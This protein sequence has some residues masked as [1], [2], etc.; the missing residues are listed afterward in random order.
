MRSLKSKI[1][2]GIA[3]IIINIEKNMPFLNSNTFSDKSYCSKMER[4]NR[5]KMKRKIRKII[6]HADVN[7][8]IYF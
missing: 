8:S 2:I 7:K 1:G 6:E 3:C 4:V 5:I